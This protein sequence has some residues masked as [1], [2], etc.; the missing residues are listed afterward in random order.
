LEGLETIPEPRILDGLARDADGHPVDV[1][2]Q[3]VHDLLEPFPR[4]QDGNTIGILKAMTAPRGAG[5]D[6]VHTHP[7]GQAAR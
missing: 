2:K 5:G 4:H 1:G 7:G 3:L 6:G